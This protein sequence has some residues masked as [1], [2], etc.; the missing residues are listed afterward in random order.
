[1]KKQ[2]VA[3]E[4]NKMILT[5]DLDLIRDQN[6][7]RSNP[8]ETGKRNVHKNIRISNSGNKRFGSDRR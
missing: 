6:N 1:M 3:K 5:L 8:T 2:G 4:M 7:Q